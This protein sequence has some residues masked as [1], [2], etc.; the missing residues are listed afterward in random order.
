MLSICLHYC[1]SIQSWDWD[2]FTYLVLKQNQ[3][4]D[5]SSQG[6]NF[7]VRDLNSCYWFHLLVVANG[8]ELI[9]PLCNQ[10]NW[11]L[12]AAAFV[13]KQL[14]TVQIDQPPL[15]H[16]SGWNNYPLWMST[17]RSMVAYVLLSAGYNVFNA[18]CR[19][20]RGS[21]LRA[22]LTESL[23]LTGLLAPSLGVEGRSALTEPSLQHPP[24]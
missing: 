21:V 16:P 11:S 7:L 2:I 23:C 15:L 6:R 10:V 9:H 3:V 13:V 24:E 19:Q 4:Q 17:D 12:M 1:E 14:P 18:W 5:T 8:T 20:V 22:L